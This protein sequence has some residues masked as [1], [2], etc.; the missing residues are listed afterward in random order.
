MDL[1]M[2]L[3]KI[4]TCPA[5]QLLGIVL[6]LFQVLY[7]DSKYTQSSQP[8]QASPEEDIAKL[9]INASTFTQD[10]DVHTSF[11]NVIDGKRK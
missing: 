2:W 9:S 3:I 1:S 5:A 4:T 6:Y 11:W 10:T 8:L 7:G